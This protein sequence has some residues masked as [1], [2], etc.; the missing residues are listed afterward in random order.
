M[1]VLRRD[2]LKYCIG[3]A[4]ALGVDFSTLGPLGRKLLAAGGGPDGPTYPI[5]PVVTTLQQTVNPF[6]SPS[7]S[8]PPTLQPPPLY[9][10]PSPPSYLPTIW[11]CQIEE[12]AANSYGE[13][14][15]VDAD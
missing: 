12:Y 14:N 3:S 15:A 2:F 1:K 4:A 9:P 7:G 13:W 11:P 6:D 10:K 5:G 8:F